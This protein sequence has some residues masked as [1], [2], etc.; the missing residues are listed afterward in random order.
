MTE[1]ARGFQPSLANMKGRKL[2]LVV[3]VAAAEGL[4]YQHVAPPLAVIGASLG[5]AK[6]PASFDF[7]DVE[8]KRFEWPP[9]GF[10]TYNSHVSIPLKETLP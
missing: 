5:R 7:R 8:R 10:P 9:S 3:V 2:L 6:V 1:S 4:A